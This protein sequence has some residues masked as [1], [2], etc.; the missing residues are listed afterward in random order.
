LQ[1]DL[2]EKKYYVLPEDMRRD[3][4]TKAYKEQL[5]IAA[6]RIDIKPSELALV[7]GMA[8]ALKSNKKALLLLDK[9]GKIEASI[10]WTDTETGLKFR[11]RPDF[12]GD[13]GIIVDLK[14]TGRA[15]NDS[16]HRTAYTQSYDLSVALTARGYKALTGQYPSEYVFLTVETESPFIIEG[17]LTFVKCNYQGGKISKSYWEIG[18]ERLSR[19]LDR[20][21]Q[22]KKTAFYPGYN[23][24]FVPM[25]APDYQVRKL[26]ET[27]E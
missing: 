25:V 21:L 6:G 9:P 12:I 19:L 23:I 15:D 4:R 13:D 11:C 7:E 1:H 26:Y 8:S 17:K 20:Y 27:E 3:A 5:D 18:E 2:F 10:F 22:C 16:F 24:D 14:T